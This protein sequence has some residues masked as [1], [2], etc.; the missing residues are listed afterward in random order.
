M[1]GGE[2]G[3]GKGDEGGRLPVGRVVN[4]KTACSGP[5]NRA[6]HLI[7]NTCAATPTTP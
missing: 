6:A 5:N 1:E 4:L 7:C 3:P 2:L